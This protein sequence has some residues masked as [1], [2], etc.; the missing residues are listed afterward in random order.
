MKSDNNSISFFKAKRIAK[1]FDIEM[2][3]TICDKEDAINPCG[4]VYN[5]LLTEGDN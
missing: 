1:A 2:R 4:K 5:V 3:L